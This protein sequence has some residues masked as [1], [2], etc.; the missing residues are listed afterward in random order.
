MKNLWI[1]SLLLLVLLLTSCE[2]VLLE[3]GFEEEPVVV[4]DALWEDVNNRYSYFEEKNIDWD[5][6][7]AVYRPMVEEGMSDIELFDL[8]AEMLFTLEDGHVNLRSDF[9]RSRNW[10]WYLDYPPNFNANIVERE[11]LGSDFRQVGPFRAQLLEEVLYVY[12]GSFGSPVEEDHLDALIEM[13]EGTTGL[14]FDIRNNG[15]GSLSNARRIAGRLTDQ[16]LVYA[17]S[18]TKTG[19]GSTDFSEWE[20]L[21]V[22]PR[23][24]NRYTGKVA[25]LT[26]RLSYSAANA[27]AQMARALPNAVLIGDRSGGGGGTPV[28]GELPNGWTYRF[29][30]T[31]TI[32]PDGEQ[33]EFGVPVDIESALQPADEQAGVDTIIE[34]ALA[35]LRG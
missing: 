4:F 9:D 27:F 10:E 23:G 13:A 26:N 6:I 8:L 33:L 1:N 31:Q 17:R 11:Y 3:E 15:G 2:K 12:Y 16:A 24:S 18:R 14:I 28:Y 5:S 20:D 29:S 19:P 34:R 35:W 30:A 22:S 32:S 25:V 21:K 7:R